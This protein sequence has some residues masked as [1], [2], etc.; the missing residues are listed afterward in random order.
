MEPQ[1]PFEASP[2]PNN[3][4]VMTRM[5]VFGLLCNA[6]ARTVARKLGCTTEWLVDVCEIERV[7]RKWRFMGCP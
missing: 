5:D 3:P 7:P 6:P 4:R 1:P 2:S